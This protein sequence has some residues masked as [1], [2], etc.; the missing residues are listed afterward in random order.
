MVQICVINL[1]L[2]AT[3]AELFRLLLRRY[4][5]SVLALFIGKKFFDYYL[6]KIGQVVGG[7]LHL[8][9]ALMEHLLEGFAQ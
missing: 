2:P 3:S 9:D 4:D 5:L 1:L 6:L 7:G 8:A